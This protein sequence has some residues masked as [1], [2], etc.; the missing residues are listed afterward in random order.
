MGILFCKFEFN[1][2]KK[3]PEITFKQSKLTLIHRKKLKVTP[4]NPD[5]TL[6]NTAKKLKVKPANSIK[7]AKSPT[8]KSDLIPQKS[9]VIPQKSDAD[10]EFEES[11]ETQ[12]E[13]LNQF[14][15]PVYTP[16]HQE[17]SQDFL[18]SNTTQ[19][20]FYDEILQECF[21]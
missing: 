12:I 20:E 21:D 2:S 10:R 5:K 8:Q 17:D 4:K 1:P 11:I 15:T 19:T 7:N 16:D 14:Y 6:Y 18:S 9:D 13:C 3:L